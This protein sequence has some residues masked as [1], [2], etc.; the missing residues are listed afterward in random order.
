MSIIIPTRINQTT[1][2]WSTDATVY[3]AY[4]ILCETNAFYGS[5]DQPKFKYA[6]GVQTWAQLDYMPLDAALSLTLAQILNNANIMSS[7]QWIQGHTNANAY[8]WFDD[9]SYFEAYVDGSSV[10][11]DSTNA[12]L[13]TSGAIIGVSDAASALAKYN[14][15]R[16]TGNHDLKGVNFNLDFT[17]VK[18]SNETASRFVVTDA[19]KNLDT[20][21]TMSTDGTLAGNS[22]TNVSSQK[23]VKTYVDTSISAATVGL[24]DDRGNYDASVNTFPASGGSGTAGAVLKGDLWTIS[25]AGTL[26]GSAVTAGDVVRALVDTPAQTASNWAIGE[27]NIGY[28]A[29]NQT[30][31]TGVVV[32]NEASTTL[33]LSVKGYYDYL[34][35]LVWMTA[36]LFGTWISGLTA[37]TTPVDAD[38]IPLM[39]SADTN[40][41]KKLSWTNIKATLKTYFDTLY[42]TLAVVQSGTST[43]SVV[44]GTDTYTTTLTPTL[45]AYATGNHFRMKVTNTNTVTNPTLN[46][47]SLGAKT[48]VGANGMALPIGFIVPN[49]IYIFVYDG[50]NMVIQA[51]MLDRRDINYFRKIGTTTLERWY[52]STSNGFSPVVVTFAQN[53][54][55]AQPFVVPKTITLDRIGMEITVIGTVGSLVRLGI[56]ASE[57]GLPTTLVLDAGTIAGDSATFQSITINQTL[58]P[59]LYYLVN[60]SN[61][62]VNITFR[63]IPIASA[64]SI[65]GVSSTLGA[66]ASGNLIQSTF[67]YAALPNTFDNTGIV[68]ASAN[69]PIISV[70][71]SL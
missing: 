21:Y 29:E 69:V 52:T 35:G 10:Q 1:L 41:T 4:K 9:G 34:V 49:G 46:I 60:L 55:K 17:N 63:A 58:A 31:K 26:G 12:F 37:K 71:L 16:S 14:L 61:S 48:I 53:L 70:R 38:F 7:G 25:V 50:T 23:A 45:T 66:T 15:I 30:N 27:T 22:D 57:N 8:L 42:T 5:T 28:A 47:D 43:Y 44:S 20:P 68:V 39:D 2:Q 51:G 24:L 13:R 62:V 3:P 56:Y 64:Q 67:T 65:M 11:I 18:L 36:Q 33:Y 19:S 59:G 32:G 54:L 6:D 40:K